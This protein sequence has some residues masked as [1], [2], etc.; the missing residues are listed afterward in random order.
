MVRTVDDM[1]PGETAFIAGIADEQL[2]VKLMEMGFLPGVAVRYLFAA[3]LG[4]PLCVSV[5]HYD[6]VLRKAEAAQIQIFN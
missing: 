3:P 6:L 2:S 5:L 4:D 1:K